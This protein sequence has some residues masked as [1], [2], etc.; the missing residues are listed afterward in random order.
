MEGLGLSQDETT[1]ALQDAFG[2]SKQTYWRKT[3]IEEIPKY[4]EL[5]ERIQVFMD[6]GMTDQEI[7]QIISTFPEVLGCGSSLLDKNIDYVRTTF[8]VRNKALNQTLLRKPEVLGNVI[9]CQVSQASR[10][11]SLLSLG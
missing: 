2:W 10:P 1:T 7:C 4:E 11:H 6:L 3:K 5:E 9:D 8:F